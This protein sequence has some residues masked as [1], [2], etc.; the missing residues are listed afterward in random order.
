[1]KHFILSIQTIVLLFL[2]LFINFSTSLQA[3][4]GNTSPI[5]DFAP[6]TPEAAA[7]LKYGEYP[8]DLSTGVPGI[9]I[10][11]YSVDIKG[12]KLPISLDYHASGIKVNQEATWVGLGWNLNAGAQV[13][14]S[15]RD[16]IDENYPDV[17][18]I[19][20]D[21]DIIAFFKQHPYR[22]NDV[23]MLNTSLDRS[24]VKDMYVFSSPTANGSFYID[25]LKEKKVVTIPPNAFK[26]ELIGGSR[27]NM[28]FKI[29]DPQGNVYSLNTTEISVKA[30]THD[31]RY[32]SAWYVDEIKTPS[33][34]KIEFLYEDDG[35][36]TDLSFSQR[37][38][39]KKITKSD[40][41]K[42]SAFSQYT[43]VGAVID[44]KSNVVT[45]SKK[46]KEIIF[47]E[48]NSKVI[49]SKTA[50]RQ[51][52]RDGNSYLSKIE[53]RDFTSIKGFVFQYSY[54]TSSSSGSNYTGKRLKLDKISDL[55]GKNEQ[56]FVY[57]N[58]A[59]PNKESKEQDYFGFYNQ[60]SNQ[61]L[62][63][64][65]YISYPYPT[66][67]G[68]A[69]RR[70]N[71]LVNQ[72]GILK[73]IHYPTKGYT[74][75][76]YA[77][78]QFFGIDLFDKYNSNI[79]NSPVIQGTGGTLQVKEKPGIDG[80]VCDNP[81]PL[82]CVNYVSIPFTAIEAKGLLTFKLDAP[83]GDNPTLLKYHYAKV[84]VFS[85]QNEVYNSGK[86]VRQEYNIPVEL[87]ESG[88]IEVEVY[89]K[90]YSVN[91]LQLKYTNNDPTPKNNLGAG[92]RIESIENYNH[93]NSLIS[94]KEYDYSDVEKP[95]QTSGKL[96]NELSATF[97]T[98]SF[99]NYNFYPCSTSQ[100]GSNGCDPLYDLQN[101]SSITSNSRYGIEGNTVIYKYVKEKQVDVLNQNNNIV[102]LYEFT[103][104]S[105]DVPLGNPGLQISTTWKR[106]KVLNK[107]IYK[108]IGLSN[109]L[110]EEEK[111]TYIEDP[112]NTSRYKGFKMWRL[113]KTNITE[114]PNNPFV[115]TC[116]YYANGL[117]IRV[118]DVIEP[119]TYDILILWYYQKASEKTSYYYD[120][121]NSLTGKVI[122]TTNF[123]Y[124][125]PE[126]LQLSSQTVKN[127]KGEI[128]E[129]KYFYAGD[130]EMTSKPF[131]N[132]LKAAYLIGVPLNTQT[133]KGGVKISEQLT[134]Y[135]KSSSTNN[136]LLPKSV[137]ANKGTA[138]IDLI[139]DK[140][141]TYDL[142]DDRGNILQYTQ[143]GGLPVSIIW[144]YNKMHPIAK[145][146]NTA[147]SSIS[148]ETI[149]N[150]QT[151]SNSDS[152]NCMSADCSEQVLR[153]AL[154]SFRNSFSDA[155]IST[156]T[157]NPLVGVTS[158]T[159][160][161]GF[162][163]YYEYDRDGRLRFVKDKDLN[164]LQKYC[165]NYK[166]QTIDCGDNSSTSVVLYKSVAQSGSF[167]KNNCPAG[168]S[169]SS[170]SFSLG[171]GAVTS[172]VSQADANALGLNKFNTDGQNYAN[173]SGSCTYY[174]VAQSGSFT[175]N[176]CAV[177]AS[178][179][180]LIYSQAAG[181]MTSNVS[182]TDA[183]ALGYSKFINDG[184][185]YANVNGYCTYYSVAQSASFTKN[186]CPAGASGS[187]VDYSQSA[188]VV[189][190]NISQAD[191]DAL[192]YSKFMNDGQSYANA[193]GYCTFYSVAQSG[194]FAKNSCN[195]GGS[196][197]TVSY[198]QSAGVVTS[199]I[200]QADADALGYSKFITDGQNYANSNGYC[201]YYSVAQSGSFTKNNCAVG[202]S[203]SS[204]IYS[205]AAGV[206][207]SNVSQTDADALG[208]SKFINDGQNYANAN[209][210]CTYYSVAQSA[211]FTKNNCPGGASGSDVNYSQSAGVITSNISQADADAL[212]YSKFINDGQSYANA[213]GYCTFYSVAQSGSFAKNSCNAGG[214]GS[215][216][217]YSQSAGVVTSNI[218]QA[219]ADA[220]G[221]SQFITDG[222]NYANS[223]GYCTYYSVAQSGSFTKND[224][225]S[226][227]LG[228]TVSY[229]QLAGVVTSNISQADADAL[230]YSKFFNDGQSYANA[231]GYCTYYSVAQSGSFTKNDCAVGGAGSN[232]NY[233]QAAG[234]LTSNISQADAD[235]LGLAK[236]Y[237]DGQS[238]ANAN[239]YCT[240][241]SVAQSGWF[242]RNNCAM[243]GT[244]SSLFYNQTTGASISNFSQADADAL[245]YAKFNTDGQYYANINGTCTFYNAAVSKVFFRNNCPA[246]TDPGS[247]TYSVSYG[248]YTSTISQEHADQLAQNAINAYGQNA[249]NAEAVCIFYSVARNGS[250]IK[251]NCD[252]GGAG[253]SVTYSQNRGVLTSTTS[254]A[255][256][257]ALGYSK[258]MNDGQAYA[259][260]NGYCTYYS[261]AQSGSFAKN[262]CGPGGVPSSVSY[263]Q[264]A[265]AEISNISQVDADA[266]GLALFYS[267][268]QANANANGTCTY[269]NA[270]ISQTFTKND[271]PANSTPGTYTYTVPAGKYTGGSQV[272][273]DNLA[274]NEMNANGQ[275]FA[276]MIAE[277][278]F[279]NTARSG[280]FVKNNCGAGLTGGSVTYSVPSGKYISNSQENADNL[281]QSE[282]NNNGQEYANTNGICLYNS[283]A[284]SGSFTKNNCGQN[285]DGSVVNYTQGAGAVTSTVSQADADAL[286]LAKFNTDGQ[287][288]AN[289]NGG[290]S[291]GFSYEY[292]FN[293]STR[294]LSLDVMASGTAHNGATLYFTIN[295]IRTSGVGSSVTQTV[296]FSAGQTSKLATITL[297]PTNRIAS[298]TLDQLIRN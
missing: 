95:L 204:L 124:N 144:G 289:A 198:S 11:L 85:G 177:G 60:R 58:I 206:M 268:G 63:P 258:F 227:G 277:C 66:E 215:T 251:N 102:S 162:S 193:N 186:N 61:D 243:G 208:Y 263:S 70:V 264:T 50:G 210:Y 222:Q 126:H 235:A 170:V 234:V 253:S 62:I 212:G 274:Q 283:I 265:G 146:E 197:S 109:E 298:V 179:S 295:F 33:N 246:N 139:L 125:N 148:P 194:A 93:D 291:V 219:D 55:Y 249:A 53:V 176:N 196:G 131:I 230:G 257:D 296:V 292:F 64:K 287:A 18:V 247:Y 231:N 110:I 168:A 48:G 285:G 92:L 150:L 271:C 252:V 122:T 132:E 76:N 226:G 237:T 190:S 262:N 113:G 129:S 36:L 279:Y 157:Y 9:S 121:S 269:S 138:E 28:R 108:T 37:V 260:A 140:K 266:K 117:D 259:N 273:V 86:L 275:Y 221:Y 127:S 79:I 31:D 248:T 40:R 217:S 290:C 133:F 24:R 187:N 153:N 297:P 68:K 185:N 80:M 91:N 106:G 184:Q 38:D 278:F 78:N 87:P 159:D 84:R 189:T 181:V 174:S 29:T 145:I 281:A 23:S 239:G 90:F 69:D 238:Y 94:K 142:Y 288:Y 276:N 192:G 112:T 267:N 224:C 119:I 98:M 256:A 180:S 25:N 22:H 240:Y 3:Q 137:Y 46:I 67:I 51:D 254:Q 195:A 47:N 188:G 149:T 118:L 173:A 56:E 167:T 116:P 228:A 272:L 155:F 16:E 12:F 178:G 99:K 182:Q 104:A 135:D 114:D 134:N 17:D 205:Q 26:V 241:Y 89:G 183:D 1:M 294:Q 169:G 96:I 107:K 191:A 49:F 154:N 158:V 175:K 44:E 83:E 232:V 13:I 166:G 202:A 15:P 245:G 141:I 270:A 201:T 123:N 160:P 163:S 164:V 143:E 280:V 19:P 209:G 71:P 45:L 103:T 225:A 282:V 77:A 236:F 54:F 5:P 216:V 7:F 32:I 120:S 284:R 101:T 65:H 105:D 100:S 218:S 35:G 250:F 73:E 242:T 165:Y 199:N 42:C 229:S 97:E 72:T 10:P 81:D 213:N 2:L 171:A 8:V 136:L 244:P 82:E 255:D 261:V 214:S 128:L 34:N 14:L 151:L 59:L 43:Q 27:E 21:D 52:L 207:T 88:T 6:K 39:I 233:N 172:T 57:S 130:S 20:N 223:H 41:E 220:L 4:T 30:L 211:S 200:S 147:Y 161:K 115:L 74:K 152:D 203:G 156:Y 111:N 286:G 75:F 293:A